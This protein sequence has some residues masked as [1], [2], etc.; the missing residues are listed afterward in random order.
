MALGP[1][2]TLYE[3]LFAGS[4]AIVTQPV[5]APAFPDPVAPS[6]FGLI[7]DPNEF[8]SDNNRSN[9]TVSALMGI[10]LDQDPTT[11]GTNTTL[12]G[13]EAM[14]SLLY[15]T[16]DSVVTLENDTGSYTLAD[17]VLNGNTLTYSIPLSMLNSDTAMDLFWA[18]DSAVGPSADFDRAPDVGAFA[19]DND[20]IVVR[21]PGD[22]TIQVS[23]SDPAPGPGN[24]DFPDIQQL[25][26]RVVGGPALPGPAPG[27]HRILPANRSPMDGVSTW[28][29]TVAAVKPFRA[30]SAGPTSRATISMSTVPTWLSLWRPWTLH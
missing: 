1:E 3:T 23:V 24:P 21:R 15:Q 7:V 18:I 22:T 2:G 17:A 30:W 28:G 19:T 26:A 14:V 5:T 16:Y 20:E 4:E 9:N 13:T 6:C 25:D 29:P 8:A 27:E 12:L 11:T 10:D